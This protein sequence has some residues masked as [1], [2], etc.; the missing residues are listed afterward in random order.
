MD[1]SIDIIVRPNPTPTGPK[2]Q[3]LF[4]MDEGKGDT[5]EL[6]FNKTKDGMKSNDVYSIKFKLKNKD[7]AALRFSK[8]PSKVL[9]AKPVASKTDACPNNDCFM[10]GVFYVDPNSSIKDEELTVINTDPAVQLFKFAFN[11]LPPGKSDPL[12]NSDYVYYDPIGN[13]ENG[14]IGKSIDSFATA[15]SMTVGGAAAGALI[16]YAATSEAVNSLYGA[17]IGGVIG[18]LMGRFLEGRRRE[19]SPA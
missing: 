12:P 1:K 14:G 5:N 19:G 7:G 10:D 6:T 4:S 2:D 11:F 3:Y 17:I 8:D 16:G 18:F 15:P 9:W 13:N